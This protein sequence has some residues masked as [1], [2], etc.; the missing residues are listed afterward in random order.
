MLFSFMHLKIGLQNNFSVI[1][2]EI[3]FIKQQVNTL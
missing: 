1:K 2:P 3:K